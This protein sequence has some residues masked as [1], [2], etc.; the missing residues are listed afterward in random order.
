M[1]PSTTT[2]FTLCS[3]L[4]KDKLNGTNY[5]DWI[6][7]M[8]IVLRAEKKEDILD[9]PLPEEPA[10]DATAAVKNAYKKACDNNLEVSCL[11]LACMEP[12]LH[13]Q[14][15]TNHET[16]DMIV[17]LQD[18]FQTQARTERF[19]VSMA[20]IESKL[21]EGAAVGPHVIKMVGYTQR[22]ELPTRPRV[23]C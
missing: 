21:A 19:N 16:H 23:G 10:D 7:K 6:R 2:S 18:I 14:F 5:T 20:F 4:E 11:M 9:T 8:R 1:A 17:S 12:E 13:M 15:E 22:L 3:I